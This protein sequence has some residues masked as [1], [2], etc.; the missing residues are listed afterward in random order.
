VFLLAAKLL[1]FG[2]PG[3]GPFGFPITPFLPPAIR[4]CAAAFA[5]LRPRFPLVT[6][7][8]WAL[9]ERAV[10]NLWSAGSLARSLA[11]LALRDVLA[12]RVEA[13]PD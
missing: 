6:A 7:P 11:R 5:A 1:T 2:A 12:P 10:D 9:V 13:R 8:F 4:V 3:F